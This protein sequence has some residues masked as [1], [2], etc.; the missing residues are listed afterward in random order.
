[1]IDVDAIYDGVLLLVQ[2][3]LERYELEVDVA[4]DGDEGVGHDLDLLAELVVRSEIFLR[5]LTV[6]G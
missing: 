5:L 2:T 3:A 6:V 1:M 4:D